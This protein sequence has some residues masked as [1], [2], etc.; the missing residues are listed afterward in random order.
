MTRRLA[1]AKT[2]R[3]RRT[4]VLPA[5]ALAAL[6]EQR[7]RQLEERLAVGPRWQDGG[8]VFTSSVGTALDA[9]DVTRRYHHHREGLGLPNVRWHHLR[10]AWATMLFEAGEN[11]CAV[12][13]VL[14]H[15]SIAT[16]ASFHS[17]VRPSMLRRF[18]DRMDEI[19]GRGCLLPRLADG[20]ACLRAARRRG[21]PAV[22]DR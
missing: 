5:V 8:L 4:I 11:L 2:E 3:F 7:R 18:A 19:P 9:R 6:R 17:H 14:G 1:L 13:R 15:A 10:H 20:T 16:T 21:R 22:D 12:S